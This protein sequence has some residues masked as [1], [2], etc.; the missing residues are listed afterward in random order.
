M[1]RRKLVD[2]VVQEADPANR[3]A[4]VVAYPILSVETPLG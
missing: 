1:R 3:D 4:A 2:V